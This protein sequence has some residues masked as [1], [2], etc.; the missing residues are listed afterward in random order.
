MNIPPVLYIQTMPARS[1]SLLTK[2][3]PIQ[4]VFSLLRLGYASLRVTV[5]I[6]DRISDLYVILNINVLHHLNTY[7]LHFVNNHRWQ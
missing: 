7:I 4:K 6:L 3:N 2:E 5:L 1:A